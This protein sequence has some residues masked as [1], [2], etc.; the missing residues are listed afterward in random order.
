M[1]RKGEE[2]MKLTDYEQKIAQYAL[3]SYRAG[4]LTDRKETMG[5]HAFANKL[6]E[7]LEA[8]CGRQ[9][10]FARKWEWGHAVYYIKPF[11]SLWEIARLEE[12]DF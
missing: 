12:E 5:T 4:L 9:L 7:G 2:R 10:E 6:L 1:E 8:S 11:Y 3:E